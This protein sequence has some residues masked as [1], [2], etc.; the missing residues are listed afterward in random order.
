MPAASGQSRVVLG[1]PTLD[2]GEPAVAGVAPAPLD[3]AAVFDAHGP[4]VLRVV[5][6]LGV[7]DREVMDVAQD[8]FLRAFTKLAD[9]DASRGSL[10]SWLY[11]YC[12]HVVA[13]HRRLR[14]HTRET[15]GHDPD[16]RATDAAGQEESVARAEARARLI[17]AL[18]T[19]TEE[20]RTVTVLHAIEELPMSEVTSILAIPLTTGY[21][22][23]EAARK[24]LRRAL[25]D[26]DVDG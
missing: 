12:V 10:R 22:R 17:A 3:E 4:Y 23:Y 25:A 5:R 11:G 1:A 21:S 16:S 8:V 18:D 19:L 6:Y 7:T 13:N 20:Q 9:W 24:A 15:L 14:R 2:E 26:G